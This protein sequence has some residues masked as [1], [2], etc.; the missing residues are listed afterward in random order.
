MLQKL[1]KE[2]S[3]EEQNRSR[4]TFSDSGKIRLDPKD[5]K[6]KLKVQSYNKATGAAEY[7][8]DDDL[9]VT[10]WLT[11]PLALKQWLGF[12]VEP[13]PAEQPAGAS[14]RYRLNDG[15]DDRYWDGGAWSVA[16]LSTHWNT[17]AEVSTNISTFPVTS[18]S[19]ALVINLLTTD[20]S[21]TPTVEKINIL[22]QCDLDYIRSLVS[23]AILTSLRDGIQPSLD[24]ALLSVGGSVVSLLDMQTR[25]NIA[26]IEAVYNH[27]QDPDHTT[28]L[29]SSYDADGKAIRL[30]AEVP[31]GESIWVD[32]KVEPEVHLN[33]S[34]QDYVEV[35]S[36]PAVVVDN[37]DLTGNQVFATQIVRNIA[38]NQAT[39]R[40]FPFR[41][42]LEFEVLLL[43]ENNQTLLAMMDKALEHQA[44]NTRFHW[45]AV[46]EYL[47]CSC[48]S[49][50][51]FRPKPNL[52]DKH[53]A[54]YTLTLHNIYLWLCPEDT[55]Y[56]V[57]RFNLNLSSPGLQGGQLWTGVKTGQP[58]TN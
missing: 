11:N 19:L 44:A 28:D 14:V 6:L 56:L 35:E 4:L 27:T 45:P 54:R 23:D 18:K 7:P 50:G 30:T 52:S 1:V 12:D 31:R 3:F 25:Y 36:L 34:S 57:Q 13:L 58:D 51:L 53:E 38:T 42:R 2:F 24:F 5:G 21:V 8:T 49:L 20:D 43:A 41:L 29:L 15:T 55:T 33:W 48:P 16:S 32:F 39:V 46:D 17:Q 26:A 40:R 10:T 9:T 22:M 37:F 47:S